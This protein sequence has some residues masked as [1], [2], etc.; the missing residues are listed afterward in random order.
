MSGSIMII[1]KIESSSTN[2][3]LIGGIAHINI[4]NKLTLTGKLNICLKQSVS[5]EGRKSRI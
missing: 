1:L 4:E 2:R 3:F 5:I